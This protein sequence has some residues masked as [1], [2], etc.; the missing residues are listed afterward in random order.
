[1]W[2]A[3]EV[4]D[5]SQSFRR[6]IHQKA[7]FHKL[8]NFARTKHRLNFETN[9]RASVFM[10]R[11]RN[12]QVWNICK[13]L[14]VL[15]S[16]CKSYASCDFMLNILS[17]SVSDTTSIEWNFP[18][19]RH[20]TAHCCTYNSMKFHSEQYRAQRLVTN[21]QRFLIYFTFRWMYIVKYSISTK[22]YLK[23]V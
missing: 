17:Y 18:T 11:E 5:P 21:R 14:M 22:V 10:Q 1:M 2:R 16:F 19:N 6:N 13:V 4:K 8:W 3:W 20:W 15:L 12:F 23:K 9:S 7:L